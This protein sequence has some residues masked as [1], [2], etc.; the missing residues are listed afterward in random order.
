MDKR[1]GQSHASSLEKVGK[2]L[3]VVCEILTEG[4]D[5]EVLPTC[6]RSLLGDVCLVPGAL[7]G[8]VSVGWRILGVIERMEA[9]DE[10][11]SLLSAFTGNYV[12]PGPSGIIMRG[13]EDILPTGRNFY[14]LDSRHLPTRVAWRVRRNLV[15]ALAAKHLEEKGRYLE[16]IAMFWMCNDMM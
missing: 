1:L 13:R 12:L 16:S 8:P 10:T 9:T 15:R 3:V 5:P 6:I 2:Q 4:T 14:T 11:S 7:G